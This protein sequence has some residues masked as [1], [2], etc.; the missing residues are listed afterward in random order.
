MKTISE[1]NA[2]LFVNRISLYLSYIRFALL[3]IWIA[4]VFFSP[5]AIGICVEYMGDS[6]H[7]LFGWIKWLSCPM[8]F[9]N[10]YVFDKDDFIKSEYEKI[11]LKKNEVQNTIY[12]YKRLKA[13]TKKMATKKLNFFEC[14]QLFEIL[15]GI[16]VDEQKIDDI[17]VV[18]GDDEAK[19]YYPDIK[20]NFNCDCESKSYIEPEENKTD[21]NET[22]NYQIDSEDVKGD[23]TTFNF[24]SITE[25]H[26]QQPIK[27]TDN[28]VM[29]WHFLDKTTNSVYC[30]ERWRDF[31]GKSHFEYTSRKEFYETKQK[32]QANSKEK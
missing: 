31:D 17:I 6:M 10:F 24:L 19:R 21:N 25:G 26:I 29:L 1:I 13:L 28:D 11:K 27:L 5:F 18:F 12:K 30:I 2:T 14:N 23:L 7:F 22:K 20:R 9:Y 4:F 16:G 8:F 32:Y 3:F 15:I